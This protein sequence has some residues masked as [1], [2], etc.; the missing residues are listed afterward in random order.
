MIALSW[1]TG[2]ANYVA[3][4]LQ[5]WK[6]FTHNWSVL[7]VCLFGNRKRHTW[8]DLVSTTGVQA[9]WP[10][11]VKICGHGV[12]LFGLSYKELMTDKQLLGKRYLILKVLLRPFH[13]HYDNYW[14]C[15]RHMGL[16]CHSNFSEKYGFIT[17]WSNRHWHV[18]VQCLVA[19][20]R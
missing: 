16:N 11:F 7:F 2:R 6:A 13:W 4:S 20:T 15:F 12:S 18:F 8:P 9:L 5:G 3:F 19:Q 14:P 1:Q 17:H 10:Y